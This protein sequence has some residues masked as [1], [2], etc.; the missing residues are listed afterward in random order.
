MAKIDWFWSNVRHYDCG[1]GKIRVVY[2]RVDEAFPL[3][4]ADYQARAKAAASAVNLARAEASLEVQEKLSE[5]LFRID[6]KNGSAQTQFRAAYMVYAAA[7]CEMVEY[8]KEE[9]G[10]IRAHD[11]E[12]RRFE[13]YSTKI[14][15]LVKLGS[16]EATVDALADVMLQTSAEEQVGVQMEK[17]TKLIEEWRK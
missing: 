10:K 6:E 7:P 11:A 2:K 9:V 8:L 16:S 3:Y 5:V 4:L 15:A 17:I 14:V 13:T 12:L 1:E